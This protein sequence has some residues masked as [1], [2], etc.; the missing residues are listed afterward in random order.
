MKS[1][2]TPCTHRGQREPGE[3][4]GPLHIAGGSANKQGNLHTRF[5]S[6]APTCQKLKVQTEAFMGGQA[7]TLSQRFILTGVSLKITG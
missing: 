7:C 5:V 4:G 1:E 3:R 6:G 2:I